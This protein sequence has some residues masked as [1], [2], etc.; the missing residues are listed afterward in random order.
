MVCC[1]THRAFAHYRNHPCALKENISDE[2]YKKCEVK[3][4]DDE[5]E[6][7]V[8]KLAKGGRSHGHNNQP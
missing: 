6:R 1:E 5:F 2:L 8:Q 4:C 7:R 3:P